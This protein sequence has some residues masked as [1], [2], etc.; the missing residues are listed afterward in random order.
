MTIILRQ[1]KSG[2]KPE[3]PVASLVWSNGLR[4]FQSGS[5]GEQQTDG[6]PTVVLAHGGLEVGGGQKLGMGLMRAPFHEEAVADAS[7]DTGHEH[8][9]RMVNAAAIIIVG[10]IQTLMQTV[11]DAA[12]TRPVE[13]QPL[14]S[15]ELLGWGAGNE[16]DVFVF[17]TLG[18]T[19]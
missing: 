17:A 15:I 19:E 14:L 18:L 12:I 2:K 7:E 4:R 1:A 9:V 11:F 8:G 10:N 3:E 6:H 16:A 5:F 13:F